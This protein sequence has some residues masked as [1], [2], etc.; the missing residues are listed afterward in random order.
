MNIPKVQFIPATKEQTLFYLCHFLIGKNVRKDWGNEIL[1]FYPPLKKL[2]ASEPS[3]SAKR[4]II[5][6]FFS[7]THDM[8]KPALEKKADVY[9]RAWNPINEDIIKALASVVEIPWS[10]YP[11]TIIARVSLNPICPRFLKQNVFDVF[12]GMSVD[13]MKATCIHELLHFIYFEKWKTVFPD[14]KER[15]FDTPYLVWHLSEMVPGIILNDE[16]IQ[17]VFKHK[18]HSY[19][20]YESVKIDGILLLTRLR[21]LYSNRKSFEE[22]LQHA[23]KFMN[24]YKRIIKGI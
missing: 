7:D 14:T 13:E 1:Y 19:K 12:R 6:R 4:Q 18:F 8:L 10:K 3:L 20:E 23:W 24:E 17:H 11:K 16:R 5:E 15:E 2:L 21:A 9:Q 22:F